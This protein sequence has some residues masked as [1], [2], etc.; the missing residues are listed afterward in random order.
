MGARNVI[1]VGCD[2]TA[3]DGNDHAHD[4]PTRWKGVDPEVRYR[5][6]AEGLAE[7]RLALRERGVALLS[8]T[9]FVGLERPENDFKRLC[10][11]TQSPSA[12]KASGDRSPGIRLSEWLRWLM[13]KFT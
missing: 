13:H 11:E 4:K 10:L 1:L 12:L 9:P 5:Q 7:V 3:I 6:Y 2:C 8:L